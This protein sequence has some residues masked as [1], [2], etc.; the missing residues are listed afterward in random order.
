MKNSEPLGAAD[1]AIEEIRE[2]RRIF[3]EFD[4]DLNKYFADL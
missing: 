3:A 4:H 1:E 2:V